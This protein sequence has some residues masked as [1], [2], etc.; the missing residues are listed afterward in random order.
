MD[1]AAFGHGLTGVDQ[2]ILDGLT[3]LSLVEKTGRQVFLDVKAGPH[4]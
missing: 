1:V 2:D 4:L 3:Y